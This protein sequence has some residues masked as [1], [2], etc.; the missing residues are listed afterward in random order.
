MHYVKQLTKEEAIA[1]AENKGYE[2]MTAK[3]IVDLQ[4]FQERLCLPFDLF[5]DSLEIMLGRSVFTHEF[6]FPEALKKEYLGEKEPPSL[7]DIIKL[8]PE[9]KRIVIFSKL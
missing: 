5:H 1:F 2:D 4:L 9:K 3:Q 8:I 7:E 6:A